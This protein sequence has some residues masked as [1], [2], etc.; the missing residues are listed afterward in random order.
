MRNGKDAHL[1]SILQFHSSPGLNLHKANEQYVVAMALQLWGGF[2]GIWR[3]RL[4]I[5]RHENERDT[6]RFLS[7]WYLGNRYVVHK[8]NFNF[9]TGANLAWLWVNT[10]EEWNPIC[11]QGPIENKL[12][13]IAKRNE[14]E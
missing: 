2:I 4:I 9:D 1:T 14:R 10:P 11:N 6:G 8:Q 12:G 13:T 3:Y 7:Y 5:D